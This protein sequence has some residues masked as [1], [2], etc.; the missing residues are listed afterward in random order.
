MRLRKAEQTRKNLENIDKD[1]NTYIT[2]KKI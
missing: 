2:D 1:K